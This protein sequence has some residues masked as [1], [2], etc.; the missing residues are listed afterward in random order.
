MVF[1]GRSGQLN[2]GMSN[3]NLA[4]QAYLSFFPNSKQL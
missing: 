4:R 1:A 3:S 2:D